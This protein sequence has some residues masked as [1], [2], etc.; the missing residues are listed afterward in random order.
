M[1]LKLKIPQTYESME[2]L[3]EHVTDLDLNLLPIYPCPNLL[4]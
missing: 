4:V 1:C 3:Y 2:A